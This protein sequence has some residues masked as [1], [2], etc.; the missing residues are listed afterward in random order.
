MR[1]SATF[2]RRP[3]SARGPVAHGT[4]TRQNRGMPAWLLCRRERPARRD[5]GHG[6]GAGARVGPPGVH[7]LRDVGDGRAVALRKERGQALR[8][9]TIGATA[10]P[11]HGQERKSHLR[12]RNSCTYGGLVR[13]YTRSGRRIAKLPISPGWCMPPPS[14]NQKPDFFG[15]IPNSPNP[16]LGIR[17]NPKSPE[18]KF[19]IDQR[20]NPQMLPSGHP[21][22][23]HLAVQNMHFRS[24]K[25]HHQNFNPNPRSQIPELQHLKSPTSEFG[26][27]PNPPRPNP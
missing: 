3:R 13:G 19:L 8:S 18:A 17:P 2:A 12:T 16:N 26:R 7:R 22:W 14:E 27:I 5:D 20:P 9:G 6:G 21:K 4:S 15:Q 1:P 11:R 23:E 25:N 10:R 24:M